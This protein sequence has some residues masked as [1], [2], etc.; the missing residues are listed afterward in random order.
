MH[1]GVF[2]EKKREEPL[3]R[4]RRRWEVYVKMY[5]KETAFEGVDWT[6]LAQHMK[7]WR[8]VVYTARNVGI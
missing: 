7:K 2:L 4:L 6:E 8:A 1:K 3:G 5:L